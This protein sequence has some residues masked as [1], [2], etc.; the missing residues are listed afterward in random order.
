M[1]VVA[2]APVPVLLGEG[3]GGAR[4]GPLRALRRLDGTSGGCGGGGCSRGWRLWWWW[5]WWCLLGE[6]DG[7]CRWRGSAGGI[8]LRRCLARAEDAKDG[9]RAGDGEGDSG[10]VPT[11]AKDG[12]GGRLR[13]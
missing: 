6:L 8:R 11:P 13:L 10:G 7:A 9:E 3:G 2:A 5:W 4:R 12:S 1:V